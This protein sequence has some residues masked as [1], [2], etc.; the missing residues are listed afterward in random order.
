MQQNTKRTDQPLQ[1]DRTV[2]DGNDQI[3]RTTYQSRSARRRA[4]AET[5]TPPRVSR[6]A[7]QMPVADEMLRDE[8]QYASRTQHRRFSEP[9]YDDD[10]QPLKKPKHYQPKKRR[11]AANIVSGVICFI[12]LLCITALGLFAA[13]QLLGVQFAMLPNYA[14]VNGNFHPFSTLL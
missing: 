4:A 14:F 3:V 7:Q 6:P 10:P 13:P 9:V 5:G 11:R 2:Y 12:C 8:G 1:Q